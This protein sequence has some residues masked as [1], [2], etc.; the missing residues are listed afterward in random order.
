MNISFQ[1]ITS[2]KTKFSLKNYKQ[3]LIYWKKYNEQMVL[4]KAQIICSN[5]N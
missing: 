1:I 4:R 2:N 3:I 5:L